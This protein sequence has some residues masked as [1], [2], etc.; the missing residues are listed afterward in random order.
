MRHPGSGEMENLITIVN[1]DNFGT[2]IKF[3][4]N[5][6]FHSL[7]EKNVN[8]N[9]KRT[10]WVIHNIRDIK[11]IEKISSCSII[12]AAP[13]T[14]E[15]KSGELIIPLKYKK[16]FISGKLTLIITQDAKDQAETLGKLIDIEKFDSWEPLIDDETLTSNTEK[17]REFYNK[18]GELLN[19]RNLNKST[20][21]IMSKYFVRNTLINA[22]LAL[23]TIQLLTRKSS[24]KHHPVLIVATGPSLD[25]QL[26]TLEKYQNLYTI[27]AVDTAWPIL[28]KNSITPDYIVALDPTSEPSWENNSIGENTF[29]TV[30]AGCAP[31]LVWSNEKNHIFTA[32]YEP[33]ARILNQMGVTIERMETGG[34][35]AT[36]AFNIGRYLEGKPIVLIGQDLALTDG[37]DHADGYM[38]K[39][40]ENVLDQA[41][42]T[43][44]MVEG[45]HG[46]QVET[47]RQLLYYKLWYE[48][49]LKASPDLMVINATE[50]GAKISGC[51]QIPFATVSEELTTFIRAPKTKP[52]IEE[53][54]FEGFKINCLIENLSS[55]IDDAEEYIALAKQGETIAADF[56]KNNQSLVFDN[57]DDI[58]QKIL[59]YNTTTRF[60]VDVFSTRFMEHVRRTTTQ[61]TARKSAKHALQKYVS[62][63][64]EIQRSGQDCMKML[65]RIL[66]FYEE[67][68]E[69]SDFDYAL[70]EKLM[71]DDAIK[72]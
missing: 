41:K 42:K 3:R 6:E 62:I 51:L 28:S 66:V 63:Y 10:V 26:A 50:G 2:N 69:S 32:S 71:A 55:L 52:Q 37:R 27:I 29:L 23:K 9:R 7:L 57:I 34:S 45:Y 38:F 47:E 15:D 18:I 22:P 17:V 65:K 40:E 58:N 64:K 39:Y 13:F 44:F 4:K 54:A 24:S 48:S 43:G 19:I 70:I 20:N 33:S 59:S 35:V 16:H 56:N 1:A 49:A 5:V 25:K 72:F 11:L 14:S 8:L 68:Q 67:L 61:D 36:T 31:G 21:L 12:L 30:D 60:V 53:A 46:D